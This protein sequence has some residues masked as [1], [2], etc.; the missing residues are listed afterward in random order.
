[1]RTFSNRLT[2]KSITFSK[3]IGIHKACAALEDMYYNLI[4]PLK[5]LRLKNENG[6]CKNGH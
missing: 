1:M 5:T 2:R 6:V 4:R 3:E